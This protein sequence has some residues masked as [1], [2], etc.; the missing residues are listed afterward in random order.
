MFDKSS[1]EEIRTQW[2]NFLQDPRISHTFYMFRLVL[3]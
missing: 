2:Q 1:T 3:E